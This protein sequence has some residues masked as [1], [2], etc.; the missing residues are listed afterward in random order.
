MYDEYWNF[1]EYKYFAVARYF[2]VIDKNVHISGDHV[3]Y[4]TENLNRKYGQLVT[5][6]TQHILSYFSNHNEY[7][8]TKNHLHLNSIDSKGL[9]K[10]FLQNLR[11][12]L[13]NFAEKLKAFIHFI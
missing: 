13:N 3:I 2:C 8:H 10:T 1:I 9:H 12:I 4:K 5:I 6:L 7:L 11:N